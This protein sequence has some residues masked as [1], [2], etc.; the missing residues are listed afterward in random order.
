VPSSQSQALSSNSSN[1]KKKKKERK[2]E[3]TW[4]FKKFVFL[5]DS[6]VEKLFMTEQV[7]ICYHTSVHMIFGG[8]N[9]LTANSLHSVSMSQIIP[10]IL[11]S[12]TTN[13]R[14]K[15]LGAR[16]YRCPAQPWLLSEKNNSKGMSYK[17]Q[18]AIRGRHNCNH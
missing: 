18:Y 14:H 3:K 11:A 9:S 2:Q 8:M 12:C 6:F 7:H 10:L 5:F 1:A 13:V 15:R 4:T 17:E 16:K